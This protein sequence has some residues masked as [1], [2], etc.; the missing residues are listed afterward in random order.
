MSTRCSVGVLENGHER[1]KPHPKGETLKNIK[2]PSQSVKSMISIEV[3]TVY[4]LG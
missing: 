1:M 4:R 2:H 3:Q